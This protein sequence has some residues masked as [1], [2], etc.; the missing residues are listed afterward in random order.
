MCALR[1]HI[2]LSVFG[3]IFSKIE[4]VMTA[5]SIPE[6]MFPKISKILLIFANII[7]FHTF[8]PKN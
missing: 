3:N 5:F 1:A 7:K 8:Q 4:K 6:K 2:N